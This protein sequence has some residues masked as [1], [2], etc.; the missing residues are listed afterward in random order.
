[1]EWLGIVT[2]IWGTIAGI[3]VARRNRGGHVF[4]TLRQNR[5]SI[6]VFD[7]DFGI[8]IFGFAGFQIIQGLDW[9][10]M[11]NQEFAQQGF[12][13]L[14]MAIFFGT[15]GVLNI[16]AS[17]NLSYLICENGLMLYTG[18]VIRWQQ[19]TSFQWHNDL[20]NQLNIQSNSKLPR[21]EFLSISVPLEQ[22]EAV[23]RLFKERIPDTARPRIN[24]AVA[25]N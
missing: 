8:V 18:S 9:H 6:K 5:Q 3:M 2:L 1:M 22:K 13:S 4:F 11:A 24:Q 23:D 21:V 7:I 19:I 14:S 15:I 10:L 25:T 12:N 17:N 20:Q 16:I